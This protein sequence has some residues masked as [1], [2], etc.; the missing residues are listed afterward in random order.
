MPSEDVAR[1]ARLL[2]EQEW[3]FARTMPKNPHHYTLRRKWARDEDFVWAVETIRRHGYRSKYGKSWYTQIDV[4]G[5]FYWTM[6][7][8]IG[9]LSWG[10]PRLQVAGTILI[11]RKPLADRQ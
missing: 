2:D 6:G 3:V 5:H 8:P 10:W 9:D 11:N 1:L 4:N 7:C